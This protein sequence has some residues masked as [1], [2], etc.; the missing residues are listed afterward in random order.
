MPRL[1]QL[2][3]DGRSTAASTIDTSAGAADAGKVPETDADGLLDMSFIDA[4]VAS[5]GAGDSG[6][7]VLLNGSGQ[8]DPTVMP[9]GVGA[10]TASVLASENL[11]AGDI[12]NIY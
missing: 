4:T 11:A 6:K 3:T 1:I 5:A 8:L 9:T 12:V 2:D 7:A 10:D